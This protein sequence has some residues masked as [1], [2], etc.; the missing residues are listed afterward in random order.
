MA[1]FWWVNQGQTYK[2]ERPGGYLWAPFAAKDGGRVRHWDSMAD[3]VPGDLVLHY[4]GQAIQAVGTVTTPARLT[5][6]PTAL[7]GDLWGDEGRNIAVTYHDVAQPIHR[8]EI[9]LEWRQ[10][11]AP[12]GPFTSDGEVKQGYLFTLTDD[13]FDSFIKE[14]SSRLPSVRKYAAQRE[15]P[16]EAKVDA[17][18]LLQHLTGVPIQ[19]ATGRINVILKVN[20]N[21]ALVGTRRSERGQKVPVA[22]V[23]QALTVLN[24]HGSV[25][26]SQIDGAHR[27]AFIGAVLLSLPGTRHEGPGPRI[28]YSEAPGENLPNGAITGQASADDS[29]NG[30]VAVQA[31]VTLRGEQSLLRR[32]LLGGADKADCAICGKTYPVGFLWAAHVKKRAACTDDERRDIANVAM[33]ACTFGC[34]ALFE[35]GL[36]SVG[37]DGTILTSKTPDPAVAAPLAMLTDRRC[38]AFTAD[39]AGYF[40]WH[41]EN[42]WLG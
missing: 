36:V 13:F 30:D 35:A 27:S 40:K 15:L 38:L 10:D 26:L 17:K 25:V 8:S 18:A 1:R 12:G 19:T 21:Q 3:P 11:K 5:P 20:D 2:Q 31:Q 39:R 41:R 34:D 29:Y 32:G 23:Q 42:T 28:G 4:W 16:A 14:F 22:W 7:S 37:E 9:P 33:L 24:D 6:R